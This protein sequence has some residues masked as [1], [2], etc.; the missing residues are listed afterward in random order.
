MIVLKVL[1]HMIAVCV[2]AAESFKMAECDSPCKVLIVACVV[3]V[4]VFIIG[5]VVGLVNG[6]KVPPAVFMHTPGDTRVLYHTHHSSVLVSL[7]QTSQSGRVLL[8]T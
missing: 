1:H 5:L 7:S 8:S 6:S 2:H 4:L 3:T